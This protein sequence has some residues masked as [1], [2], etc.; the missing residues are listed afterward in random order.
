MNT[1][2]RLA[3]YGAGLVMAFGA[4]FAVAG[5]VVPDGV[6]ASWQQ[7][8]DT[9]SHDD[10]GGARDTGAAEHASDGPATQ[11]QRTSVTD[12]YTVTLDGDLTAGRSS[13]LTITVERD[14]QPVT[15]LQPYQGAFGRMAALREEDLT[16]VRVQAD[17]GDP[18][19]DDMAGPR[20][21]FTAEV[22]AQGRY[23]LFLDFQVDDEVHTAEFV[24]DA[25]H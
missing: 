5:A 19:P 24:I 3:L 20:I 18:G 15:R 4:A 6:V 1:G 2:I 13:G 22:P 9:N 10:A 16:Y 12:G 21:G 17:G 14:G 7:Q 23:L 25:G 11:V 8:A